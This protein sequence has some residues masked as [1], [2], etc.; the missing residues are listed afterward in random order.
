GLSIPKIGASDW[1][2]ALAR[3]FGHGVVET[4][5]ALVPLVCSG[6]PWQRFEALSGVSL[7][8]G[9]AADAPRRSPAFHEDLLFTHRGLSGPACATPSR[10]PADASE[11][12]SPSCCHAGSP[13][14]GCRRRRGLPSAGS[15][16]FATA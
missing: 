15:P 9:I 6:L 14:R 12:C 16:T 2:Y 4:G 3:Q 7:P 5:P 8:V 10:S 11:R 13:R 1:G